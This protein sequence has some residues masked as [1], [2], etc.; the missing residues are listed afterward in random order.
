VQWSAA[1]GAA[2]AEALNQARIYL[3]PGARALYL[4]ATGDRTLSAERA[5]VSS[6][7]AIDQKD[8]DKLTALAYALQERDI[9]A[10]RR[11]LTLGA[12]PEIPVGELEMPVALIPVINADAEGV[13][14]MRGFGVNYSKL[15]YRGASAYDIAK[16]AGDGALL[17]AL[18]NKQAEL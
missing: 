15:R 6:G 14:L 1:S 5:L 2:R 18:G 12:H 4:L 10:A 13:R 11:L 17:E 16:Q 8:N 7:E 3:P 9:A